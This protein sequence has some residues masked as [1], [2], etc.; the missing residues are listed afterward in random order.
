MS[1]D[2]VLLDDD[3]D[4][5]DGEAVFQDDSDS[6]EV[7]DG[8][9]LTWIEQLRN[10]PNVGQGGITL[11]RLKH[12]AGFDP[13]SNSPEY[14]HFKR[15]NDDATGAQFVVAKAFQKNPE[16]VS[17]EEA[18][19]HLVMTKLLAGMSAN[20]KQALA[21]CMGRAVDYRGTFQTSMSSSVAATM[22]ER[23]SDVLRV[24]HRFRR[25]V[26]GCCR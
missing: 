14:Y 12:D 19:F 7:D 25:C 16:D 23:N 10:D 17:A 20:Q 24:V 2:D 11:D 26:V 9:I 1:I 18:K 3:D 8:P 15:G 22:R 5:G 21:Y 4:K 13:E 6:Q